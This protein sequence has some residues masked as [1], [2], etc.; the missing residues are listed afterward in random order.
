MPE[1]IEAFVAKLQEQGVQTGQA[2]AQKLTD[3][4][5]SQAE[6]ILADAQAQAKSILADAQKEADGMIVRAQTEMDLAARDTIAK[7]RESLADCL[8]AIIADSAR[9]TL[10]DIDFLGKTLHDIIVLYA[11]ADV[12]RKMRIHINVPADVRENLKAWAFRE[13]GQEVIERHR[14]SIDLK[15]K[16]KQ[17]GF[18]YEVKDATVEVTL[19]SV[20]ETLSEMVT[21]ALRERLIAAAKATPQ[22]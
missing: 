4:A 21:P 19:D 17:A 20:V 15:G 5:Q 2:E 22:G 1:T 9:V 14:P 13:L 18:E 7:L 3:Q 6:S 11:N 8:Q 16:L 10:T 12:E